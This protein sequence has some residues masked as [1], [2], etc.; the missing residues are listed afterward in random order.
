VDAAVGAVVAGAGACTFCMT[1]AGVAAP[2]STIDSCPPARAASAMGTGI[3]LVPSTTAAAEAAGAAAVVFSAL[4]LTK[5]GAATGASSAGGG[6]ADACAAGVIVV[7]AAATTSVVGKLAA[8]AATGCCICSW[9]W[10]RVA[11]SC[12]GSSARPTA[13]TFS[14]GWLLAATGCVTYCAAAVEEGA[15]CAAYCIFAG[16]ACTTAGAPPAASPAADISAAAAKGAST[17]AGGR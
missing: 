6:G 7:G 3:R 10:R 16:W 12:V 1:A 15:G 14:E 9:A 8:L 2:V 5:A 13:A 17:A 4:C 11:S